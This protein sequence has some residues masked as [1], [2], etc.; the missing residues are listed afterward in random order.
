MA[1]Q[2]YAGILGVAAGSMGLIALLDAN[3]S[4]QVSLWPLYIAPVVL[5]SWE[6]G[7]LEGAVCACAATVLLMVSSMFSGHP[8]ASQWAF[9][10][11]TTSQMTGLVTI[12]WL[13]A[14]LSA[15]RSLLKKLLQVS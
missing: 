7:L 6:I 8:Y 1:K 5:V 13:S 2:S 15:T 10:F 12:A 9:L 4:S 11:A 14:R 3:T